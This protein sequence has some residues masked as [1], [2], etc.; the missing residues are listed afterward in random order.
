MSDERIGMK[1]FPEKKLPGSGNSQR[2][3][4][5]FTWVDLPINDKHTSRDTSTLSFF[6]FYPP[7]LCNCSISIPPTTKSMI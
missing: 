5:I 3:S 2:Q 1:D 4:K 7:P 6:D